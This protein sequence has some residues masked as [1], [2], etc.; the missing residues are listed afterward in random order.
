M[1]KDDRDGYTRVQ[2]KS[3]DNETSGKLVNT[4]VK[5]TCAM[6]KEDTIT[7]ERLES[8]EKMKR[9]QMIKMKGRQVGSVCSRKLRRESVKIVVLL[10]IVQASLVY[11]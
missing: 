4:S 8:D 11:N 2:D 5:E 7:K 10:S 3:R 6:Y 1:I 9:L